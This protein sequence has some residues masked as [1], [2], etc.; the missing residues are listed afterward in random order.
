[1]DNQ[2]KLYPKSYLMEIC[3]FFG[4]NISRVFA[5]NVVL[6]PSLCSLGPSVCS[7]KITVY[8]V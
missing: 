2:K 1:V 4:E 8:A 5:D 7:L 6:R 3:A